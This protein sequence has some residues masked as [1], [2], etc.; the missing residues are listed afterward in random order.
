MFEIEHLLRSVLIVGG[1]V[2]GIEFAA[3]LAKLGT[4]VTI[5]EVMDQIL[6]GF[7]AEIVR[8]GNRFLSG[9]G[10]KIYTKATV[11]GSKIADGTVESIIKKAD[12]ETIEKG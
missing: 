1:G 2:I 9:L 7:D 4:H 10:I 5:V 8:Y 6:P 12:G 11:S 3:A